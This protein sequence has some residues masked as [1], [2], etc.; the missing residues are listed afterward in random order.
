MNWQSLVCFEPIILHTHQDMQD[1]SVLA[2]SLTK[3][4]EI[5]ED[6]IIS[7]L[8]LR[9]GR[10]KNSEYHE[11]TAFFHL[12]DASKNKMQKSVLGDFLSISNPMGN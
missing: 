5:K 4:W 11:A 10:K 3:T 2:D 12:K 7:K 9:T 8:Q 6:Q 1:V